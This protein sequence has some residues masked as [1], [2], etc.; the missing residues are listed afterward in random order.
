VTGVG[1]ANSRPDRVR[2]AARAPKR[3]LSRAGEPGL[4]LSTAR[5]A[6]WLAAR[7]ALYPTGL[8]PGRQDGVTGTDEELRTADEIRRMP[9]HGPGNPRDVPVLFLHG[10]VDNRSV[11][12]RLRTTLAR[13]GFTSLLNMNYPVLTA[14][15]PAAARQ[16]AEVVERICIRTGYERINL[17]SHSM[18]GLIGRYYVQ[19]L[20]GDAR[21]AVL[22]TLATPHAGTAAARLLPYGIVRQ[23]RPESPL[24][25]ELAAPAPGCRTR[26]VSIYS[27]HDVM[28]VPSVSGRLDHADLDVRNVLLPGAGHHT[29]PNDRRAI[30]EIDHA[31]GGDPY[32][33]GDFAAEPEPEANA[34]SGVDHGA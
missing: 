34:P 4:L 18:G 16:L 14:D 6:G 30:D 21:V 28:V 20:G 15:I 27:D 22:V 19:R 32:P 24:I 7:V 11:F 25:A 1:T 3:L 33:S 10:L 2:A 9:G 8:G 13:R 12:L 17:V 23:L 5:E 26:I 31:L 29:L